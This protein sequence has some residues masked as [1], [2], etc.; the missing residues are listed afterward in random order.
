M[1]SER[2]FAQELNFSREQQN[3]IVDTDIIVHISNTKSE[4]FLVWAFFDCFTWMLQLAV[5][6]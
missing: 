2:D 6:A 5:V 3:I 4:E 1:I